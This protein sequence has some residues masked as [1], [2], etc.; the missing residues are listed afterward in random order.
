MG[1]GRAGQARAGRQQSARE[2]PSRENLREQCGPG[3]SMVLLRCE[4]ARAGP[5]ELCT[6]RREE[7]FI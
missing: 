3:A 1:E 7:G 5:R 6:S 2:C 4:H